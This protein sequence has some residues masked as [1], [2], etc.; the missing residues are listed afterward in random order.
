LR[1]QNEEIAEKLRLEA[2]T[3]KAAM[4]EERIKIEQAKQARIEA[5]LANTLEIA[6]QLTAEKN[7]VEAALESG[8]KMEQRLKAKKMRLENA[9]ADALEKESLLIT[10]KMKIEAALAAASSEAWSA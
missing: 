1:A 7:R 2:A 3:A 10:E 8:A 4:M 5:V 9:L 6:G